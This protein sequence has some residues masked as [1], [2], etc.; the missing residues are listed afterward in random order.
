MQER[1][2]DNPLLHMACAATRLFFRLMRLASR[3]AYTLHPITNL[4]GII[5]NMQAIRFWPDLRVRASRLIW[6]K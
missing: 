3:R 5:G 2:N 4:I 1:L 6:A